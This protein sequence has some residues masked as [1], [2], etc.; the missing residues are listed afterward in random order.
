MNKD[1]TKVKTNSTNQNVFS[2]KENRKVVAL[3]L[4]RI[5]NNIVFIGRRR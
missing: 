2:T 1:N 4:E 3:E 5:S